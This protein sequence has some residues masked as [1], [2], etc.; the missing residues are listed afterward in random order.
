VKTSQ[1]S[2][3]APRMKAEGSMPLKKYKLA[4]ELFFCWLLPFASLLFCFNFY[5]KSLSTEMAFFL[6]LFPALT[7]YFV[8]GIGAGFCKFW[9]FTTAYAIGGVMLTIGLIYS[10]VINLATV[11]FISLL[12]QKSV[13]YIPLVGIFTSFAA[14]FIDIF[15]LGAGLF[16]L[17]NKKYPLGSNPVKHAFS[18]GIVFFGIVGVWNAL[19]I[20][21]GYHLITENR[22]SLLKC[23]LMLPILFAAPFM[24]YFL[25]K[26]R[27]LKRM[28]LA[29]GKVA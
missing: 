18:Y 2:I 16:Y 21:L 6:V 29:Y 13:L 27:G 3:E 11:L 14:T 17:K 25:W 15:L 4:I 20:S 7:M 5:E 24:F 26:W 1:V 23:L 9:Y 12:M 10:T 8:V 19:G 28:K 22:A